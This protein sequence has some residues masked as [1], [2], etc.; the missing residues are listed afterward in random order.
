MEALAESGTVWDGQL[1]SMDM[2]N[3]SVIG[4][5]TI[6]VERRINTATL[7]AYDM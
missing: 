5:R 6:R 7:S 1:H 2:P 4:L 3:E